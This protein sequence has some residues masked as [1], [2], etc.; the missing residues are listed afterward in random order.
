MGVPRWLTALLILRMEV[1]VRMNTITAARTLLVLCML[2]GGLTASEPEVGQRFRDCPECPDMVVVPSG[3]FRMGAPESEKGSH[4]NERPVHTV[5]VPSFAAGVYEVTFAEWDACV[6]A[7]GCGG[8][9]LD[10]FLGRNRAHRPVVYVSWA[11]A[12]LYVLWLS[13]RTGERYRLLSESEWEYAARAGTTGPFHTGATI[14]TDEANFDGRYSGGLS[15]GQTL[16][17]GSFPANGFGLHDVHGNVWE[18][19]QDC[20]NSSYE[21]AP[22]DGSAWES[23]NCSYRVLR[24]GDWRCRPRLLHSANRN[25]IGTGA[26]RSYFGFRVARTLTP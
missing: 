12:Q 26:R 10:D 20:W 17:V 9:R 1:D 5:S 25:R 4:D 2:S 24:G 21:G 23:G 19:V 11:D 14:T 22:V 16:E 6:A 15:W 18:W 13:V 8:R 3:T 7:G